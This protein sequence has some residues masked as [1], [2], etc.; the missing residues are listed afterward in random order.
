MFKLFL[1]LYLLPLPPGE[2]RGEG[3]AH[4]NYFLRIPKYL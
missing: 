4:L 1:A 2:G 3:I